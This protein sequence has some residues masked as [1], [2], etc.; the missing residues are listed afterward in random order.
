[1]PLLNKIKYDK[2]PPWRDATLFLIVC[3]GERREVQYFEFFNELDSKL[4]VIPVP[5][6]EG[7][8]APNHLQINA[9]KA[10]ISEVS[11]GG[12]YEL[13]VVLDIDSWQ[14]KAIH[15]VQKFCKNKNNWHVAISNPCFEV[16][17]YFHFEKAKPIMN[18]LSKCK[19]WKQLVNQAVAGGFD[20]MRHPTLIQEANK[21]AKTNYS[22]KGYLP[23]VAS[24][25]LFELGKKIYSLTKRV[26]DKYEVNE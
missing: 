7:K 4:K 18:E 5:S 25:Q 17:L 26:L 12:I 22:A 6:E 9:E 21:N 13:W 20:P 24:T 15:E 10:V 19:E 14:E 1:M 23:D 3:E 11:D 8:S 2:I 16:W